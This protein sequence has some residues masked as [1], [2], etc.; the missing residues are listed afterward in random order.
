MSGIQGLSSDQQQVYNQLINDAGTVN[1]SRAAVDKELQVAMDAGLSFQEA[2]AQVRND[3]PTLTPPK[4]SSGALG[5]WVGV[6]SPMASINALITEMS[7]EQRKE[8][9]EVMKAQTDSIAM[10]MEQ[11]A[12]EIRKKAV[13]QL[14]CGVVSGAIN[15]GMGAVQFGMGMKQLNMGKQ[16][17]ALA[18]EQG[19]LGKQQTDIANKQADLKSLRSEGAKLSGDELKQFNAEY[20]SR[21][22]S[23]KADMTDVK[24]QMKTLDAKSGALGAQSQSYGVM[25]QSM[26]QLGQGVSGHR[27]FRRGFHRGAVRRRHEGDGSRSG[28]DA[29]QPRCVEEHQRQP[30]R[31]DPEVDLHAGRHPA[32]YEPDPFTDFGI[33][34]RMAINGISTQ[35]VSGISPNAGVSANGGAS[36]ESVSNAISAAANKGITP[37]GP[38]VTERDSRGSTYGFTPYH[39]HNG[40][41]MVYLES[42]SASG[43]VS[44]MPLKLEQLE[45]LCSRRGIA[46]PSLQYN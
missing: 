15:I 30:V 10:S 23:L 27:R 37:A 42:R 33:G 14:V 20:S 11:Q 2:A 4:S 46:V 3:L 29:G 45:S 1:V 28:A 39:D 26:S 32:E 41:K 9:R 18:K 13:A 31:I 36:I 35:Q 7:A 22:A 25:G 44:H 24:T 5:A 38:T 12:D 19:V 34:G 17:G 6:A 21:K 8:N 40:N 43:V 16:Q